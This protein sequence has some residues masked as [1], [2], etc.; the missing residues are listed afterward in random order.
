ME[1]AEMEKKKK[2]N[3]SKVKGEKTLEERRTKALER[4]AE[5]ANILVILALLLLV[6]YLRWKHR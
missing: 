4:M 2:K 1:R 6:K 5:S 3:A